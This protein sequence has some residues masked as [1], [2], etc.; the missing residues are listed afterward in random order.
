[1]RDQSNFAEQD[2]QQKTARVLI[3][4]DTG[5]NIELLDVMLR[6]NGYTQVKAAKDPLE[7][8]PLIESFRP[9]LLLLD[10]M[11]PKLDGFGV[12]EQIRATLPIED[13]PLIVAM[14]AH[15]VSEMRRRALECGATEFLS[16]PCDPGEVL[17]RLRNLLCLRLL[18]RHLQDQNRDLQVGMEKATAQQRETENALEALRQSRER[19]ELVMHGTQDG[20]W[21]WDLRTGEVYFGPRWMEMLGY[22][23]NE[24]PNR[25]ET[26]RDLVHP[27]DLERAQNTL[28]DYLYGTVPVY[29]LEHRLR[30]KD[31]SYHHILAR[32][33][34]LRDE[35]GKPFRMAGSHFDLTPTKR[36]E[37]EIREL[38]VDLERRVADRTH[39]LAAANKELE[40]FAYSVSHTLRAPLRAI[41]GFA[42]ILIED[43]LDELSPPARE[44]LQTVRTSAD[45]MRQLVDDL[46]AFARLS[47]QPLRKQR[48]QPAQTAQEA[49]DELRPEHA[50]RAVEISI[51]D[52]P[53]CD[54]D[55]ALLKC[56]WLNLLSN[57]LKYSAK[58]GLTGSDP[59]TENGTGSAPRTTVIEIGALQNG[60]VPANLPDAPL[61]DEPIYFVRDNGVGFDMLD[62][63]RLFGV[64]QR[65]HS[66]NDFE[67][68]GVGLAI[69]QNII[70][71]HGGQVWAHSEPG[72][73]AT[74]MFT[75]NQ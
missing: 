2:E 7:A 66:A 70:E 61:N 21:D 68:T 71:R 48:I 20:V 69:V 32:G 62:A 46:L 8:V 18:Q 30:H 45:Q 52:L 23:E 15:S 49:V 1:M 43:H 4:D 50:G 13:R 51:R 60:D 73:G 27:D 74:F 56:V 39:Q 47:R 63:D 22:A 37:A 11:L 26:W 64:F 33:V 40:A 29:Y 5:G 9:D 67:G 16:R 59:S 38:N 44:H 65:L 55:P 54:A 75:L 72:Q 28:Q 17:L 24:L 36:A 53:A 25:F 12:M 35:S 31:G 6:V 3:V 41:N 19:F 10:L 42:G 57:S 58:P 14:A 34:A